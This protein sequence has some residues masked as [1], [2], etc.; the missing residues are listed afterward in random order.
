MSKMPGIAP[1][2]IDGV[3]MA[4]ELDLEIDGTATT[5]TGENSLT[6][7]TYEEIPMPSMSGTVETDAV[8]AEVKVIGAG[9]VTDEVGGTTITIDCTAGKVLGTMTIGVGELDEPDDGDDGSGGGAGGG[10]TTPTSGS[11][12]PQTG[13]GDSLPVMA[14]WAS[15]LTLLGA[16]A[17]LLVP[18]VRRKVEA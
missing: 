1:V 17:L 12:L 10:T 3:G 8:D 5:L 6:L 13:G 14:L 15:G 4:V 7:A 11:T 2:P 9:I 18:G 16:A